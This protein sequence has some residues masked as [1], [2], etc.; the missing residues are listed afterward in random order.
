MNRIFRWTPGW[1]LLLFC[2]GCVST[3]GKEGLVVEIKNGEKF[4]RGLVGTWRCERNKWEIVFEENGTLS[5]VM[6]PLGYVW[7]E[8]G[9]ILSVPMK[10]GH[11]S[12]YVPGEWKASYD[13]QTGVLAVDIIMNSFEIQMGDDTLTGDG[14]DIF[15][16]P[17]NLETGVW[18]AEWY[19]VA[20]YIVNTETLKDHPLDTSGDPWQGVVTFIRGETLPW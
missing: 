9:K 8:P 14:S 12:T 1:L 18:E 17:V 3:P 13:Y 7:I 5:W 4:P 20:T 11:L 6:N 2:I 15:T 16:G 10:Y 19:N